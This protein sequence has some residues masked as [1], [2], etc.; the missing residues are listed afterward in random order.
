M[1]PATLS[2]ETESRAEGRIFYALRDSL[3]N[4][5]TVFHSFDQA[6][7]H[8]AGCMIQDTRG[9]SYGYQSTDDDKGGE[10]ANVLLTQH[11]AQQA[12]S[13]TTNNTE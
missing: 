6:E 9:R 12:L 3:D 13:L 2:P 10:P 5:Y 7:K 4:S 11:S 8:D 1:I